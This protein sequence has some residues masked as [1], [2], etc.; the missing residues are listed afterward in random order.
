MICTYVIINSLLFYVL[1]KTGHTLLA[2]PKIQ[3]P[4][5]QSCPGGRIPIDGNAPECK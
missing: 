2:A 3:K 4:T 1:N 5:K